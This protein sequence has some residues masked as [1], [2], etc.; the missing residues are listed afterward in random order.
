MHCEKRINQWSN[1]AKAADEKIFYCK[2][3]G[4]CW[5]SIVYDRKIKDKKN[6]YIE[7]RYRNFVSY[8]KKRKQCSRCATS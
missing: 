1:D 7:R 8:G 4:H 6:T 2:S 5:D 3:C